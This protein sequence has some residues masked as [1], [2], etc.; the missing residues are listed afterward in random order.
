[1]IK[2]PSLKLKTGIAYI[3]ESTEEQD[4]GFSPDNQ[5]RSIEKFASEHNIQIVE[6]YKDLVSGTDALKRDDF[7]RMI[8]D[9]M[10]HKFEV[11]LVYHTSRFAR[12]VK[13][14]RHYKELL[15]KK[16]GIDVTSVTQNFGNDWNDPSSFLNEGI[17]ELFDEHT[18][19]QISFWV[20]NSLME[21][22]TQGKQ[23]GNP[24]A[25]YTKKKIGFDKEK[26]RPIYDPEW[27]IDPLGAKNVKKIY[28]LYATGRYSY[29]DVAV[30]MN[31]AK[32]RTKSGRPYTYST[33]KDIL[34]N[35]VYLGMVFSRKKNYPTIKGIH[36]AIISQKLFDKVQDAIAGRRNTFGRPV[37]Q[38]RFYLLQ[39]LVYCYYSYKELKGKE[40]DPNARMLPKMY[41]QY[42]KWKNGEYLAYGCKFRKE[43][44]SCK[45]PIVKADVIDK[46][47]LDFMEGFN[48]PS[49]II[50]HTLSKLKDLF[51]Q[52]S[53]S[54]K[55]TSIVDKLQA[56]KKKV[57]FQW[58]NTEE[59][60]EAEY[61]QQIKDINSELKK[62]ESLG[63][64]NN[65]G[66]LKEAEYTKKTEKFLKDFKQFWH[67]I[68]MEEKREWIQTTIKRI[69]VQDQKVVAIEPH[70]DFKPL[71]VAHRKVVARAPSGTPTKD[72]SKS[73]IGLSYS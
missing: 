73:G 39:G 59:L 37:A 8:T 63:L 71:F 1:M 64:V 9:A 12:N 38:H 5:R 60:T 4:K 6:W 28:L 30:E 29:A 49:D 54:V 48:I 32:A 22:R 35:K 24:P 19:R 52:A 27:R 45:Q 11:I 34:S 58:Q 50:E 13:E 72:I 46:Q 20:R 61:L 68:D 14:A 56:R 41:A 65:N 40:N 44:K 16:L 3:R 26:G 7:Q 69:W 47:V 33:I 55:D 23:T 36:P 15:R 62:Y 67:T 2:K 42:Y 10:L 21:K 18:S 57:N 43:N 70:D 31:K 53:Q 51:K 17:N 66:K 25:G